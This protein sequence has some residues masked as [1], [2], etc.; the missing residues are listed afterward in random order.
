M[1]AAAQA[2]CGAA[3]QVEGPAFGVVKFKFAFDSHRA[4]IPNR[5]PGQENLLTSPESVLAARDSAVAQDAPRGRH[6]MPSFVLRVS[7][8]PA[9]R[10]AASARLLSL[11]RR[12]L[13]V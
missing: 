1:A 12:S 11:G 9:R 13:K 2:D 4:V 3:R 6:S 8:A 10:A 5:Y 7:E